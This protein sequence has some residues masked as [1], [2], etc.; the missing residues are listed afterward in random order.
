MSQS[1][2][3]QHEIDIAELPADDDAVFETT[4]PP[5]AAANEVAS[6]QGASTPA[7]TATAAASATPATVAK[8]QKPK[9]RTYTKRGGASASDAKTADDSDEDEVRFICN[10]VNF[11]DAV[12]YVAVQVVGVVILY[13]LHVEC[14]ILV[15]F[16]HL[17][18]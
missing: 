10:V 13:N 14:L 15:G 5:S 3:T 4:P 2:E 11:F 17:R 16:L 9:K 7:S 12:A 8:P 18:F 1:Q 6:N